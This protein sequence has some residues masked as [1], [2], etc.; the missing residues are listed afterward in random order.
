[1]PHLEIAFDPGLA[2]LL[3]TLLLIGLSVAFY[4]R[5]SAE[6]PEPSVPEPSRPASSSRKT[7]EAFVPDEYASLPP[8][9]SHSSEAKAQDSPTAEAPDEQG[10]SFWDY[11]A[12]N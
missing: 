12:E 1:M 5:F 9:V 2:A 3:M 11:A 6:S 7:P 4:L 10:R 8:S